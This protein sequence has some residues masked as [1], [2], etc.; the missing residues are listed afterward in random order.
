[1]HWKDLKIGS[2]IGLGFFVIIL[3]I[4]IVE[5]ISLISMIK[6]KSNSIN[7]SK[8]YIPIIHRTFL[9][10]EY[11]FDIKNSLSMY[12]KYGDDF[13]RKNASNDCTKFNEILDFL[14]TMTGH[15][16]EFNSSNTKFIS[17][18]QHVDEYVHIVTLYSMMTKSCFDDLNQI[19]NFL[20]P[21][22]KKFSNKIEVSRVN[23][24]VNYISSLEFQAINEEKPALINDLNKQIEDLEREHDNNLSSFIKA[25]QKFQE[26]F[27]LAKNLEI[28]RLELEN[29]IGWE[30]KSIADIG[31]EGLLVMGENNVSIIS[32]EQLLLIIAALTVII[33]SILLV[34]FLINLISIPIN[35]GIAIAN[36]IAEGDLT[37][38]YDIERKDEVGL[39]A[40]AM[41]K[42]SQNLREIVSRLQENSNTI[43]VTSYKL[44]FNANE[45]SIGTRQQ[46][47]SV[48]E[49]STSLEEMYSN[50]HQSVENTKETQRIA[51]LSVSAINKSKES[52]QLATNSL[53]QIS[54][55]ISFIN[56]L[57]FKTN[58][59]ALNAAIEAARAREYGRGF[60]VV[61]SEVKH[62]AD[63]SRDSAQSINE[64]STSTNSRATN[65]KT[66][67]EE[68]IPEI[69]KTAV[70][71]KEITLANVEHLSG[72]EQINKAMQQL[73]T[74]VQNNSQFAEDLAQSANALQSQ[75][76][77][78]R[79]VISTFQL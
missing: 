13:Y 10:N 15:S 3:M 37:F 20:V 54:E 31:F 62:L 38:Q 43:D 33:I 51:E 11:W 73:N 9:I 19:N 67:L 44:K 39:L 27:I 4:V 25:S 57:S 35:Q 5:T 14:V 22:Q 45:I 53:S 24:L 36:K 56:D 12:D 21:F 66:E 29:H 2:K 61:A 60:A 74:V 48:E 32:K 77:E 18:K 34:Y 28:R 71:I 17:I 58:L 75:S 7:L 46:A 6:I 30:I 65:A 49:I 70:L 50:I 55:K 52:F 23:T 26:D 47:A 69:I 63:K 76:D 59:L 1:M 68:L 78:L 40:K 64:V 8:E 72:V 16:I 79:N 41:N 42:V